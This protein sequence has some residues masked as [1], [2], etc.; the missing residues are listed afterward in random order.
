MLAQR[1]A[2]LLLAD[3]DAPG[4][5]RL[6]ERLMHSGCTCSALVTDTG[7]EAALYALAQTATVTMYVNATSGGAPSTTITRASPSS[8]AR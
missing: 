8:C 7:Q 3:I 6:V 5:E 2:R 4:L 1:G